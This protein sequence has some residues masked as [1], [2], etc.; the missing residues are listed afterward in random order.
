MWWKKYL[1]A[2][3]RKEELGE[4][5]TKRPHLAPHITMFHAN[6]KINKKGC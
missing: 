2:S 3:K 1:K 6:Q 5:T 4:L